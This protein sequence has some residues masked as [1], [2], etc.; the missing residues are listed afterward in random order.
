MRPGPGRRRRGERR[1]LEAAARHFR[2]AC[3]L[4][5]VTAA[6][7]GQGTGE[8]PA[9]PGSAPSLEAL[10]EEVLSALAAGDT[11]R[12][13]A[14]RL[15]E[16]EHNELVWPELPAADPA[17]N[18]PVDV[19]WRNI[20][21]RNVRARSRLLAR[22]AGRDLELVGVECL[23]PTREFRS[24]A[25]RTGCRTTYRVDGGGPVREVLFEHV[26]VWSGRHKVFRYYE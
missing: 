8:A 5:A 10:A 11:G 13:E 22:R 16:R 18:F 20:E 4:A 23:G 19:A 7:C 17:A 2:G 3:I 24:F 25:V 12:L 9:L 15:T 14:L 21:S 6:G 1:S 26:L